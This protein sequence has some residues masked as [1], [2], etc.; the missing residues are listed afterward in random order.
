MLLFTKSKEANALIKV[1]EAEI[2]LLKKEITYKVKAVWYQW[3]YAFQ[4]ID[5]YNQ[6]LD[7]MRNYL[8]KLNKK[9]AIGDV[10]KVELGLAEIYKSELQT[11]LAKAEI[12]FKEAESLLKQ[13]TFLKENITVPEEAK[14]DVVPESLISSEGLTSTSLLIKEEAKIQLSKR[15]MGTAQSNYFPEFTVGYFSQEIDGVSGFQGIMIGA[16]IPIFNR[17]RVGKVKRSKI[18]T[19]I[20]ENE[21]EQKKNELE[22]G[23]NH[24]I[25]KLNKYKEL[26][27]EYNESWIKQIKLLMESSLLELET[28]EIDYYRFVQANS[29]ALDIE[30]SRLSLINQL[31]QTYF[32]V[33]YYSAPI[34]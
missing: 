9:Q 6:Q 30:A 14:L 3:V 27:Q 12:D 4:L 18:Q 22:V 26:Y 11:K 5:L 1:Q 7:I 20:Q 31:N 13:L 2:Q 28:G 24:T 23:L 17:T 29:K 15:E 21:Y 25:S 8:V 34:N 16:S 19:Q 32:E 10:S 33:E